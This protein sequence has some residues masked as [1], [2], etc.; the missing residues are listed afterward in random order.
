MSNAILI[1]G[2]T[3][4][5]RRELRAAG[6]IFD[7]NEMGY[8]VSAENATA[9]DI[10]ERHGLDVDDYDATDEQLT[11]ATGERL[12]AIRQDR[13][14]RRRARLLDRAERAERRAG[15]AM[16][17]ISDGERS[18]L[19]L[20]E[21]VKVGHHSER[22]HRKLLDRFASAMD[23]SCEES[24]YARE[25]RSSAE[26][27]GD[28]VVKGDAEKRRQARRDAADAVISVGDLVDTCHMGRAVVLAI[29]TKTYRVR[30]ESSG[31]I[32]AHDKSY[33]SLIE[34]REPEA[35][36]LPKFKKGDRV[37]VH[38]FTR[39]DLPGVIL[40]RTPRG[41]SVRYDLGNATRPIITK[42]T[43]AETD[44]KPAA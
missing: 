18:F 32:Y 16:N 21:P 27:M 29:N 20:G 43:F 6:C 12:R 8:I 5:H 17:R 25:L 37:L 39:G 33:C 14:D 19:S 1:T 2:N 30:L 23:K 35:P 9:R 7:R 40:R 31:S 3:Y 42:D 4:Q 44:I 26:W 22:R 11:P 10:A 41:Y 24:S 15:E 13:I 36:A 38:H 34:K 28:A